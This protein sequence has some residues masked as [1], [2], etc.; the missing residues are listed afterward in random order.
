MIRTMRES[1]AQAGIRGPMLLL[2][3]PL[4][5][6]GACLL[7]VDRIVSR[8]VRQLL[9]PLRRRAEP[10]LD[11][12]FDPL[13]RSRLFAAPFGLLSREVPHLLSSEEP[14]PWQLLVRLR[15][16]RIVLIVLITLQWS[17]LLV[18]GAAGIALLLEL[19]EQ[20]AQ[21]A[22]VGG[23]AVM[24]VCGLP[25]L[26]V[27]SYH[28]TQVKRWRAFGQ[29]LCP[30]CGDIREGNICPQCPGCGTD[31]PPVRPDDVPPEVEQWAPLINETAVFLPLPSFVVGCQ[32]V[33]KLH[34]WS[35]VWLP[36]AILGGL[37]ISLTTIAVAAIVQVLRRHA[38][39]SRYG[40]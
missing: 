22:F 21:A 8:P 24:A 31:D 6:V 25:G 34:G 39:P 2:V 27:F 33:G 38:L 12:L 29:Y 18:V 35:P 15:R 30:S 36:V 1:A 19:A 20:V 28:Q 37:M 4:M 9:S 7:A 3:L 10:V 17:A 32:I 23:F 13:F 40:M 14:D 16:A 26:A 11:R 5:V